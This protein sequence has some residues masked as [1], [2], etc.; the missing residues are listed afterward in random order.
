MAIVMKAE[1]R[2]QEEKFCRESVRQGDER[3]SCKLEKQK[4]KEK[5]SYILMDVL[6]R[7]PTKRS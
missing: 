6:M 3:D 2:F 5:N 4:N 1:L 7:L